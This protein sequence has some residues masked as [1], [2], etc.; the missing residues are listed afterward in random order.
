M[1]NNLINHAMD[2]MPKRG[3]SEKPAA[4]KGGSEV[5]N[6]RKA[7]VR[8]AQEGGSRAEGR[9]E[10]P[11]IGPGETHIKH[12]VRELH[13]QH[14]IHHSD[15]GPHH[16]TDHHIRHQPLHGMTPSKGYGR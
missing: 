8:G 7:D 11:R 3:A 9:S 15:H 6:E 1:K 14:P 2:E 12:A 16:G 10:T 4:S 13:E 5:G